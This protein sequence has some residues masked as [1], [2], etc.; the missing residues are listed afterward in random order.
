LVYNFI[1]KCKVPAASKT[2]IISET[3]S[4][5]GIFLQVVPRIGRKTGFIPFIRVMASVITNSKFV[6]QSE[7]DETVVYSDQPETFMF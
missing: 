4:G 2:V 5:G 1:N 7:K 3:L 6:E